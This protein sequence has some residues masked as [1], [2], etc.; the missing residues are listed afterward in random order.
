[1]DLKP[2]MM[3][4][5]P[6]EV[7]AGPFSNERSVLVKILESPW[8]GFVDVRFLQ[9]PIP[10]GE[11]MIR[12]QIAA[13]QGSSIMVSLPGHPVDS[14]HVRSIEKEKADMVPIVPVPA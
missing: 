11:T 13:I 3:V 14:S 9:N 10:A 5:I 4:W 2:G 7:K 12:G 8:V 6:C 1:M